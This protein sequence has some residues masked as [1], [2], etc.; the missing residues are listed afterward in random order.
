MK[1]SRLSLASI[2]RTVQDFIA[3][4]TSESYKN[5]KLTGGS[6]K[7]IREAKVCDMR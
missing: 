1:S 2:L 6:G 3:R 7:F 5:G 4:F